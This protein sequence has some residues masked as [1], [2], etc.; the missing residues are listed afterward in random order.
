MLRKILYILGIMLAVIV[1]FLV[2]GI[3]IN[4]PLNSTVFPELKTPLNIAHRGGQ[5]LWPE[6]SMYAFEKAVEF[7]VDIVELDVRPTA[8]GYIVVMHDDTVDRTC[9]AKG[10]VDQM[11]LA[12][13]Q[14]LDYAYHFIPANEAEPV[15]RGK[16]ITITTLDSVFSRFPDVYFNIEIKPDLPDFA[17]KVID[18]VR[19]YK[20]Q[21]KVLLTSFH[22]R[23][24]KHIIAICSG[25]TC[26][27]R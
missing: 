8:D 16:G 24:L 26:Y 3:I 17:E 12:Q 1:A 14:Q 27:R 7:G 25:T 5:Y 21:E 22:E 18:L 15:F 10:R 6:N 11:T 20:M 19:S 23:V 9:D 4:K 13:L 2:V